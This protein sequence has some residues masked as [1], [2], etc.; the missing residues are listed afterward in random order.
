MFLMTPG[1]RRSCHSIHGVFVA[2][3][4]IESTSLRAHALRRC[5]ELARRDPSRTSG[6]LPADESRS[7]ALTVAGGRVILLMLF[8]AARTFA[9]LGWR[10]LQIP[11]LSR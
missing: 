3:M 4:W 11:T 7:T 1:V 2:T 6:H 5:A 9:H 8:G 10:A